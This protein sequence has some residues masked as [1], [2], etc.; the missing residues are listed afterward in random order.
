LTGRG[1][2]IKEAIAQYINTQAGVDTITSD[3]VGEFSEKIPS[4]IAIKA[5]ESL[6]KEGG[7][8]FK[9]MQIQSATIPGLWS[10]V[11]DEMTQTWAIVGDIV[12]QFLGIHTWLQR[13]VDFLGS[14]RNFLTYMHKEHPILTGIVMT[15]IMFFSILGPILWAFGGIIVNI[16][17]MTAA[18]YALNWATGGATAG[19]GIFKALLIAVKFLLGSTTVLVLGWAAAILGVVIAIGIIYY[20]WET[21]VEYFMWSIE[22]LIRG[23]QRIGSAVSGAFTGVTDFFGSIFTENKSTVDLNLNMNDPGNVI[24]SYDSKIH[25]PA[26][27]N[28]ALGYNF[29]GPQ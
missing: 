5:F 12:D 26:I 29:R 18:M 1:I 9:A 17:L 11:S 15:F 27:A 2:P 4:E 24:E 16:A 7:V 20:N 23:F 28:L 14:I 22:V 19:F 3:I 8:A 10:N 21:I 25:G 6:N 13:T